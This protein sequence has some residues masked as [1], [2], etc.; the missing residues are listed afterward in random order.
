VLI[1]PPRNGR[2]RGEQSRSYDTAVRAY[3]PK[4]GAWRVTAVFPIY[5][6]TV[7]LIAREQGDEIWLEGVSPDGDSLRW[8]FSEFSDE[9]V[10]WQG[11][12]SKDDGTTWV[13]DEE[14]I[15]T[16]RPR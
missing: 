3:D 4:L 7:N 8:T 2:K 1:V 16:R 9:R 15:L 6:A 14:I 11:Y 13:R 10:L 5:G 12:V